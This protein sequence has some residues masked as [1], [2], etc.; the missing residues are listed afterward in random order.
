MWRSIGSDVGAQSGLVT[1]TVKAL[2]GFSGSVSNAVDVVVAWGQ[3]S[4]VQ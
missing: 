4:L 3:V 1:V 2:N